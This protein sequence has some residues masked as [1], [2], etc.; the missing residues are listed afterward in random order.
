M[1]AP[2]ARLGPRLASVQDAGVFSLQRSVIRHKLPAFFW[3]NACRSLVSATLG[4]ST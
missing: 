2:F 1:L 3:M 4:Q